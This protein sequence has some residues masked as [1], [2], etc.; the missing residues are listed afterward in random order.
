M[1]FN[2][3]L[4]YYSEITKKHYTDDKILECSTCNCRISAGHVFIYSY[5]WT[6]HDTIEQFSCGRCHKEIKPLG[7]VMEER[8][9]YVVASIPLN[10]RPI[11]LRQPQLKRGSCSDIFEAALR[12]IAD[13]VVVDRTRIAG[14]ESWD[15]ACIGAPIEKDRYLDMP[16]KPEET[17][18]LLQQLRYAKPVLPKNEKKQL[19]VDE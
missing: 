17:E 7:R 10:A 2:Q 5:A 6:K 18:Y 19:G 9:V 4:L 8:I 13:E 12:Q 15:G 14:R 11:V 3:I 1:T 16:L